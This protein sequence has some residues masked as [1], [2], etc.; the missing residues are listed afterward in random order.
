MRGDLTTAKRLEYPHTQY[1]VCGIPT[2]VLPIDPATKYGELGSPP[3]ATLVV[4]RGE[5]T[6]F[7]PV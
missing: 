3:G 2:P 4:V 6:I 5:R 1:A 7:Q